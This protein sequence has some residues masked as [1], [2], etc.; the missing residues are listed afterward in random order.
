MAVGGT[1]AGGPRREPGGCHTVPGT[2]LVHP[3]G[4]LEVREKV[5]PLETTIDKIG[6]HPVSE[7]RVNLANPL[8]GTLP[9]KAVS[10]TTDRFA[11]G[12]F[13][14]LTDDQKLSRPA[15]E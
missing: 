5:V 14:E 13:L 4:G 7:R 6:G 15:F 11:S 9:P 12:Q 1:R 2:V 3:L 8:I 10:Q